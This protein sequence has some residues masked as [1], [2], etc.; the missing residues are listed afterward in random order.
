MTTS[1]GAEVID[2]SRSRA[3]V[4]QN[5]SA[6]AWARVNWEVVFLGALLLAVYQPWNSSL[7]PVT[8]FGVFL[9]QQGAAHSLFGR[10]ENL[11]HYYVNDGRLCLVQYIEVAFATMAFGVWAQGWYWMYFVINAVAVV[12]GRAFML[13]TGASRMMT[14]VAIALWSTMGPVAETWIRP[15]GEPFVLIFILIAMLLA[16]NYGES[17]AWRSRAIMIAGCAVGVAYSKEILVV[18]LPLVWLV[19]RLEVKDGV[20]RWASWS[21]KDRFLLVVVTLAL[22][23]ALIPIA[24]VAATA[25]AK[26]YAA[27]YGHSLHPLAATRDRLESVLI[28]STPRL[29]RLVNLW[30]DPGWTLLFTLPNLLWLRI[31]AGAVFSGAKKRKIWP[32]ILAGIWVTIGLLV[33]LPWPTAFEFYMFP[34]AFGAMFG[35][36]HALTAMVDGKKSR[37]R[38]VMLA[39]LLLIT[40][41]SVE[42]RNTVYHREL[43]AELYAKSIDMISRMGGIDVLVG[44][45]PGPGPDRGGW[46]RTISG[47]GA[48]TRGMRAGESHDMS[49]ADA[50]KWL[51]GKSTGVVIS[52][53]WGCGKLFRGSTRVS[54]VVPQ[55][56]WPWLWRKINVEADMYVAVAPQA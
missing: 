21:H 10:V 51:H 8:D 52:T 26:A 15:T 3:R 54:A 13:K 28:P 5:S 22:T 33:Y 53:G 50:A 1:V 34:F 32:L 18:L 44:A 47:F 2:I 24:Y 31:L 20:W 12:L 4:N 55:Y 7:L 27:Q 16:F 9:P 14:F 23:A 48:A 25:P 45:T 6:L 43:R 11:V 29:H 35:S 37:A 19:S 38:G 40:V 42:A 41:S 56:Q 49:C 36:A 30:V 17:D 39:A 46:A